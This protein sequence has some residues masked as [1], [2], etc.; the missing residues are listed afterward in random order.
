MIKKYFKN[1]V[2]NVNRRKTVFKIPKIKR[3]KD[4]NQLDL[5]ILIL[6]CFHDISYQQGFKLYFTSMCKIRPIKIDFAE[7]FSFSQSCKEV[8]A[9]FIQLRLKEF[10][11]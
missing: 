5:Q 11:F 10:R 4:R 6:A 7:S 2:I 3:S 1:M 9:G 8:Y